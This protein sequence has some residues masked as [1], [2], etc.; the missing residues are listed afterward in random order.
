MAII[1]NELRLGSAQAFSASGATTS[2]LDSGVARNLGSGEPM[3]MVFTV[4]T[5]ADHTTGDES[6]SFAVQ[7]DSSSA[8]GSAV[9]NITLDVANTTL[10]AGYKVVLPLGPTTTR[11]IRGYLTLGGTTPS[12]S[13]TTDI[14][15]LEDVRK[16]AYYSAG[17]TIA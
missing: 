2:Y 1:D 8:F 17:Y 16:M 12:V 11:Y 9:D 4:T 10:V 7:S 5:A 13:V 3:A 6:Y 14:V 15:P